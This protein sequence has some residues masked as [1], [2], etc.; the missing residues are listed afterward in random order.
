MEDKKKRSYFFGE[1]FLLAEIS[2]DIILGISF[3]IISNVEINFAIWDFYWKTYI[4]AK[5]LSI[6]RQVE[7]IRK[8]NFTVEVLDPEDKTFIVHIVFICQISDVYP[9]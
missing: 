9:F 4:A 7:L 6:I 1:T 8:K 3:I 2:M 5:A